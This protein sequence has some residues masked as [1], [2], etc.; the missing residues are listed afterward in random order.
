MQATQGIASGPP[1]SLDLRLTVT[2]SHN[3]KPGGPYFA[4]DKDL[5]GS[6]S[7]IVGQPLIE[8]EDFSLSH[9]LTGTLGAYWQQDYG[10]TPVGG[11]RYEQELK[12][13]EEFDLIYGAGIDWLSFDG[14]RE[15]D[16]SFNV[17]L[18]WKF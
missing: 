12:L 1:A 5:L 9:R 17:K 16:T 6:V 2:G 11:L 4:P 18:R 14:D 7:A 10:S 3:D 8:R 13:G 15:T